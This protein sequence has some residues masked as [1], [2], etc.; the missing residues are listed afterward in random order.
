MASMLDPSI[1]SMLGSTRPR[2]VGD[3]IAN[4]DNL[5]M[6]DL[7]SRVDELSREDRRSF[8][9]W[10]AKQSKKDAKAAK[11]EEEQRKK[12]AEAAA[13]EIR[14]EL[15][16]MPL[17]TEDGGAKGKKAVTEADT[18]DV[19]LD[20][21][22]FDE[23]TDGK[24]YLVSMVS[25]EE[26]IPAMVFDNERDAHYIAKMNNAMLKS[27][28]DKNVK[29]SIAKLQV[30][31]VP[32][33]PEQG[34]ESV[35]DAVAR[36]TDEY[37][38]KLETA[39]ELYDKTVEKADALSEEVDKLKKQISDLQGEINANKKALKSAEKSADEANAREKQALKQRD[40]ARNKAE[41]IVSQIDELREERNSIISENEA[42]KQHLADAANV[43][44]DGMIGAR[45]ALLE[46][47][48]D[49]VSQLKAIGALYP[50]RLYIS[51]KAIDGAKDY[52]GNLKE[53][54][55]LLNAV[56]NELWT[57]KFTGD[58]TRR[59]ED[60][61]T[62]VTGFGLAMNESKSTTCDSTLMAQRRVTVDGVDY[63]CIAHVKGRNNKTAL[64]LHFDFDLDNRRIIVGHCGK[65]LDTA[66]SSRKGF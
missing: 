9:R 28:S 13:R 2:T 65:H 34:A 49:L 51:G 23:L 5:D 21:E 45:K 61:F 18:I 52:K 44:V 58:G 22:G 46:W 19:D 33:V 54:W 50:E 17:D 24:S 40:E 56:A 57:C 36:V 31:A 53:S 35:E 26:F 42:M 29:Q 10:Q 8:E 4:K 30:Y 7:Y 27:V 12:D 47:P 37:E 64:R 11:K 20:N 62:N 1:K 25:D 6:L 59:L 14:E 39:S 48:D 16:T 15:D 63:D 66:G 43:T 41:D 55:E 32:H 38:E 3:M 60:A